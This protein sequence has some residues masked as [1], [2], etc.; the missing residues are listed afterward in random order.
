MNLTNLSLYKT[1]KQLP[2]VDLH[3]HL[4]GSLRLETLVEVAQHALSSTIPWD[5]ES[6]RPYVQFIEEQ[7]SYV[8]FL[9]KFYILRRFYISPEMIQRYVREAIEDAAKDNIRYLELRFSPQALANLR[10]YDLAEVTDW[11]IEATAQASKDFGIGVGLLVCLLRHEAIATAEKV[12]QIAVDR[13][14]KGIV[15]IDLTGNEAEFPGQPFAGIFQSAKQAGLHITIHAGEGAGASSI[16]TAIET[17]GA[18]RIGHGVRLL[19]DRQTQEIAFERQIPLE[20]CLTS[21]L[22]TGVVP[23]LERHPLAQ[24][25][26]AELAITLNSD[27]PSVSD[28]VLTDDFYLAVEHLNVPIEQ[29]CRTVLQSAQ[30]A[31]LPAI[32]RNQLVSQLQTELLSSVPTLSGQL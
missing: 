7:P 18:D 8:T 28:M 19:E 9:E 6:L 3:R 10:G 25:L 22:Q 30:V 20:L 13:M 14:D 11:V 17:L 5:K 23:K 16:R 21:N 12:A 31:F 1:I 4:E 29:V 32:Q 24:L 27:D 26:D 15:G 2:K